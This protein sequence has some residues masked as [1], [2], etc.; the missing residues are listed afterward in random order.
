M[1]KLDKIGG[2]LVNYTY[3]KRKMFDYLL[4]VARQ[5][6]ISKRKL[7][8]GLYN[9]STFNKMCLDINRL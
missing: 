6:N 9:S 4:G 7:C 3:N 2:I 1:V 5:R 8:E